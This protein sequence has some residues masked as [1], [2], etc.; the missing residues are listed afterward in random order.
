MATKSITVPN[1]GT[2]KLYKRKGLRS[3][4][5]SV[6]HDST[7]RVSLPYWLPFSA[8]VDFVHKQRVWIKSQQHD[9][10][11]LYDGSRIGKAHRLTFIPEQSRITTVSRIASNG[12]IRIFYP[13]EL[14]ITDRGVQDTAQR[15]SI[16]ALKQQSK[17]LLPQ[18]L[19]Y[20]ARQHEFE[21][22]NVHI[23]QLKSRW[24]SCS[25]ER[26]I[27]LNCFLMQLPWHLIDYVLLHELVHT[28]IMAHGTVFWSELG[29]YV[30]N[31]KQARK[32]MKS[33]RPILTPENTEGYQ[34]SRDIFAE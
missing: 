34:A 16:R 1:L 28:K 25:Q 30:P 6:G 4:R 11:V 14:D 15:A 12:E 22:R 23:K 17:K 7:V 24:G 33:Y 13:S 19:R 2:V 21:Y 31:L 32:E 8:G 3:I 27:V 18:R 10:T 29:Q 5:L 26:D 20:L 9:D